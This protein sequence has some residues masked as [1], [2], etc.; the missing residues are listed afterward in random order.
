MT[1]KR[2]HRRTIAVSALACI[3]LLCATGCGGPKISVGSTLTYADITNYQT[4][5]VS[6]TSHTNIDNQ[7]GVPVPGLVIREAS[8]MRNAADLSGSARHQFVIFEDFFFGNLACGSYWRSQDEK[9]QGLDIPVYNTSKTRVL[10]VTVD[11]SKRVQQVEWASAAHVQ[12]SVDT[13]D[14]GRVFVP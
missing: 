11:A 4:F 5:A 12:L 8:L 9:R 6:S 10:I 14:F 13:N 1:T 7:N 3:A 2:E